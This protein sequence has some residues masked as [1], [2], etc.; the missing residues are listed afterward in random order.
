MTISR[1]TSIVTNIMI[2]MLLLQPFAT[3]NMWPKVLARQINII[4]WI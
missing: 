1:I 4:I 3:T 2:S